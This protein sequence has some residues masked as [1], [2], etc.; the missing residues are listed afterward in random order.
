MPTINHGAAFSGAG[1]SFRSTTNYT[2]GVYI[3]NEHAIKKMD[4][5]FAKKSYT[6]SAANLSNFSWANANAITVES[7]GK[8]RI[9]AYDFGA[10][11]GSRM[12]DLHEV[13]T[14]R[15]TYQL[16]QVFSARETFEKIYSDDSLN[17]RK[18]ARTL[19]TIN[20]K[21]MVDVDTYR[22]KTWANGAG[23]T[24]VVTS[25]GLAIN[26]A[27]ATAAA[28]TTSNIVKTLLQA[29]AY[30]DNMNVPENG[31][32]FF[33]SIT[34]AY[35]IF[36]LADELKYQ[37]EFTNKGAINGAIRKLGKAT[38]VAIPDARM[39]A[40]CKVLCKWKGASADPRKMT[41]TKIYPNVEGYSG[42]IL[43]GIWRYD[44][45]ILAHKANG[46]LVI[47]DNSSNGAPQTT[48]TM[49]LGTSG[50]AGKIVIT[51]ASADKIFYTIDGHNPKIED[52]GSSVVLGGTATSGAVKLTNPTADCYIQAYAV[53]AG[54]VNSGI[55]KY[56]YHYDATTPTLTA[57]TYDQDIE[58]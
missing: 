18:L 15:N 14:E 51:S 48:P 26:N 52:N 50:D 46:V 19:K 25:G 38:I 3:L 44:S 34:D 27:S 17:E 4:E 36:Q 31:R 35:T 16:K 9:N 10:A 33:V 53:K 43:N 12:G 40:G 29:N 24:F 8:G 58:I 1:A 5:D 7:E 23:N 30:L 21:L 2:N 42:P 54:K 37:Q 6:N 49:A 57:L 47:G 20:E 11:L 32:L 45:F 55:A 39:P 56:F 22:L 28:L 13:N 41:W